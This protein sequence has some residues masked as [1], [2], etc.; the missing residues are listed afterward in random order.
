MRRSRKKHPFTGDTTTGV[1]PSI[2][3]PREFI[4]ARV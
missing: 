4:A 3:L 1:A 2:A